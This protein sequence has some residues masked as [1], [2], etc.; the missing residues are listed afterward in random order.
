MDVSLTFLWKMLWCL[1]SHLFELCFTLFTY[2][3]TTAVG[4]PCR[5]SCFYSARYTTSQELVASDPDEQ[6]E[7]CDRMLILC[8]TD[9]HIQTFNL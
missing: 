8:F 9:C 7:V 5:S 2:V 1:C 3:I 4:L 6:S